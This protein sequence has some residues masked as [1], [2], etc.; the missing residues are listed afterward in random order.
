MNLA[1]SA[2]VFALVLV[3]MF[4]RPR[5]LSEAASACIGAAL[6]LLF[7]LAT[8]R[9]VLN[10]LRETANVL[11]F[12]L[13]MMIVTCVAER[14]G[15]FDALAVIAARFSR[16][17]G[18]L[19]LVNVFLL[20]ALITAFLS[21]DVT[22]IVLTPI[23][24]AV[25][26]RLRID[27]RPYLF[28]CAFVA[29]TASLFLPVSNL[30]NILM[31]DLLHL[32]FGRFLTV[33][34]LPNLGALA[35]NIGIFFGIFRK[36]IARRFAARLDAPEQ[37]PGFSVA[38]LGLGAVLVGLLVCGFGAVPLAFPALVGAV[39]LGAYALSRRLV[40]PRAL[41]QGVS[42]PLFPFVIAM[43]IVIR[44]VERAWLPHLGT[45]PTGSDL[46]TLL[47]IAFGTAVGANLINNIPMVAAMIRLLQAVHPIPEPAAFATLIGTNIGPSIITF[48]SLATMLWLA[49][50]R[51]RGLNVT[52]RSYLR[53]G[54]VTT[55]PML[56]AATFIL[57]AVLRVL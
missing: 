46:P 20:G 16:G 1:L 44:G 15:V 35:V 10:I 47:G 41:V 23:V 32:S 11:L 34:F 2:A 14:G 50:V 4:V 25:T 36:R 13:G 18:R 49:L 57:W 12:L 52:A 3:L 24:Y 7:R 8:P 55:P 5:D 53:V 17:S 26:T 51:K 40:A 45:L 38:A 28:A 33:M 54:I 29:N 43:F 19:L 48:G 42:W 30:T 6:M 56:L 37:P 39:V 21:L 27:P 31:Y 9:D 22:V